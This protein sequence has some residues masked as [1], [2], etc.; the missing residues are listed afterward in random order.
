MRFNRLAPLFAIVSFPIFS[1]AC[2][3]V[4]LD[5]AEVEDYQIE[6]VAT[7]GQALTDSAGGTGVGGSTLATGGDPYRGG[8]TDS[9]G[10]EFGTGGELATGGA[11]GTGGD[12][13]GGS[14]NIPES[15]YKDCPAPQIILA[16]HGFE[17]GTPPNEYVSYGSSV[18]RTNA[19]A[20][21]G[22]YSISAYQ[23]GPRDEAEKWDDFELVAEGSVYVRSWLYLEPGSVTD[24]IKFSSVNG[25]VAGSLDI[26]LHG[27]A[28]IEIDSHESTDSAFS[29]PGVTPMGQWFCYQLQVE[30]SD[31]VGAVHVWIDG[32]HAVSSIGL[33]TLPED[34]ASEVSQPGL[35]EALRWAAACSAWRSGI[36]NVGTTSGASESTTLGASIR[37]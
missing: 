17:N 1:G 20:Y 9:G 29:A 2:G 37:V 5:V 4:G 21:Q 3:Y 13:S 19:K 7:G 18:Q 14:G 15:C 31:T 24:W 22:Q 32:E 28:S 23:D 6:G 26:N 10:T 27:D 12:A 25:T 34:I 30:V 11:F 33:D 36:R 8:G 16:D 35:D